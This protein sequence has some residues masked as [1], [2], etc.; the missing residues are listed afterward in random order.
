[1]RKMKRIA[2]NISLAAMTVLVSCSQKQE[3][4]LS[5]L[6]EFDVELPEEL[7]WFNT[8]Y[9]LELTPDIK[10]DTY[11]YDGDASLGTSYT[12][13]DVTEAVRVAEFLEE[14]VFPLFPEG[15]IYRYM[16]ACIFVADEVSIDYTYEVYDFADGR[17]IHT[18]ESYPRNIYGDIG[19]RQLTFAA[20]MLDDEP[21]KQ[22]LR[23]EW[24][25]LMLERMM[26]SIN[27]WSTPA[28]FMNVAE[29]RLEEYFGPYSYY[30]KESLSSTGTT[31]GMPCSP[32]EDDF[33][34]WYY[35]GAVRGARYGYELH[36]I[37]TK[38][39]ADY[40]TEDG[41]SGEESE[42]YVY[43]KPTWKQ[44]F[45]DIIAYIMVYGQ[46]GWEAL[47]QRISGLELVEESEDDAGNP[48]VET[49][50]CE[51]E[52]FDTRLEYVRD[53]M[54]GHFSWDI[55]GSND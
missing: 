55:Y 52:V 34:I 10:A 29:D 31:F 42:A 43:S 11:F 49:Y 3:Y 19:S 22:R 18:I 38:A 17:V 41:V 1:M 20:S 9:R 45:A 7:D 35:C 5:W 53:Y 12:E 36:W 44:E 21:D 40:Y 16:P 50:V 13:T 32:D 33:S 51:R 14:E 26:S 23:F 30:Y 27:L 24:A 48:V 2:L 15:F 28:D 54:I 47:M 46:D 37:N 8:A 6:D 39:F 25:S 4:D